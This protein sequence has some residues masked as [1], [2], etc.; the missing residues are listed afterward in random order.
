[1]KIPL[2]VL[3]ACAALA[4]SAEAQSRRPPLPREPM[5]AVVDGRIRTDMETVQINDAPCLALR[6]VQRLFGGK[7]A[8]RRVSRQVTYQL[9][10]RRAEFSLD[11]S[12]A[13]LQG[14]AVPLETEVRWWTGDAYVPISLLS[15]PEFQEFAGASV[16]WDAAPRSLVVDTVPGVSSPE[17]HS[18][19]GRSRVVLEL[20]PRVH[21]RVLS[22]RNG[23]LVVRFFGGRCGR[24]E[25][26]EVKDGLV[27]SVRLKPKSRS[28]DLH[29]QTAAGA[30]DP[31]VRLEESP[32][33]LVVE[34]PAAPGST[35]VPPS[36]KAPPVPPLAPVPAGPRAVPSISFDDI[37]P[38]PSDNKQS[39]PPSL[40]A[41]SAI[42]TIVVDAGHGGKDAGAVGPRGVLEKDINLQ[43]ARALAKALEKDGRFDVILTRRDDEFIPLEDRTRLANEKKADLFISI[44]CNAALSRKSSGFEVYFLSEK[45]TDEAAAA[46]ARR[47]NSVLELEGLTGKAK[48]KI[49]DLLWSMAKTE[50]MNESSEV[51]ALIAGQAK[52]RLS[53]PSRG[54]K[55]AAF[56]V[57]KGADMPAVLVE[58]A[59]IT[60]P[61][62]EGLLRSRRFQNDIVSALR[63]AVL[64]YEKRKTQA[65]ARA[66]S[67]S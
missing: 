16:R 42:R 62:E 46:V 41:P 24:E 23:L 53:V 8:W 47:E 21:Y 18:L 36:A 56:Y 55:Q 9:H 58:S 60:H 34:V 20:A 61:Q 5:T 30:A 63:G 38:A 29:I 27:E 13:V 37:I 15:S 66:S 40:R 44:H 17:L 57:L 35:G 54:V 67:G 64:D 4:A 26:L 2:C 3:A 51:A 45:A 39:P 32:R 19:D 12:T 7:S 22:R 28:C 25:S 14:R 59:F 43:I 6:D 33:R 49:Q 1:M 65:R 50:T 10:G 48:L 52:R 11:A 31:R